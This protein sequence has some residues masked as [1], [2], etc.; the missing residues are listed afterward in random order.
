M[1][2]FSQWHVGGRK[3]GG[4]PKN[5]RVFL[6]VLFPVSDPSISGVDPTSGPQRPT[7]NAGPNFVLG[8]A[9]ILFGAAA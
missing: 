7:A 9:E 3:V 8:A 1:A 2:C 5:R 6:P 4:S